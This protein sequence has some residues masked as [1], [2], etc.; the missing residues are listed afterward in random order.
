MIQ[1]AWHEAGRLEAG[2]HEEGKLEAGSLE[3]G[4]PRS[5]AQ[6]VANGTDLRWT[7][8]PLGPDTST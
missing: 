1:R 8:G 3:A 7:R 4:S 5:P 6:I 2:R